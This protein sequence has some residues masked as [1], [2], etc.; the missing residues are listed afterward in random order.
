MS[1]FARDFEGGMSKDLGWHGSGFDIDIGASG[2]C[3]GQSM[4]SSAI[5]QNQGLWVSA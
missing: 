3:L 5:N 2:I 1:A 4:V